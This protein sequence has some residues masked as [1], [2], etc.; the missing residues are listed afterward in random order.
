MCI[1]RTNRRL[2]L[3]AKMVDDGPHAAKDATERRM[4]PDLAAATCPAPFLAT[5]TFVMGLL[6]GR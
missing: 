3:C 6:L 5:T 4:T 1:E 2:N